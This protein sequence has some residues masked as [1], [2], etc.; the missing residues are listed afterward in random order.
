MCNNVQFML[1]ALPEEQ[2]QFPALKNKMSRV[3]TCKGLTSLQSG[4]KHFKLTAIL[5]QN[6]ETE[7]GH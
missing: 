2:I 7:K 5:A 6:R 3:I 4:L 1:L